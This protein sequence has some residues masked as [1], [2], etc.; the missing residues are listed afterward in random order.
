MLTDGSFSSSSP[1]DIDDLC[2]FSFP[3]CLGVFTMES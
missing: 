3:G 2:I 1:G